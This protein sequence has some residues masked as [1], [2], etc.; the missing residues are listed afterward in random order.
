MKKYLTAVL[1]V[2]L[3]IG[4]A[5]MGNFVKAGTREIK[6]TDV[7]W[8]MAEGILKEKTFSGIDKIQKAPDRK[9]TREEYLTLLIRAA[10][11]SQNQKAY[12]KMDDRDKRNISPKYRGYIGKAEQLGILA[13]DGKPLSP[14]KVLTKADAAYYLGKLTGAAYYTPLAYK[15]CQKVSDAGIYIRGLLAANV[16][17]AQNGIRYQ[18]G[19][20]LSWKEAAGYIRKAERQGLFSAK[21]ISIYGGTFLEEKEENRLLCPYGIAAASDGSIYVADKGSN[22]IKRYENGTMRIIAGKYTGKDAYGGETGGYRDDLAAAAIFNHPEDLCIT[23]DGTIFV[24]DT[25]NHVIRRIKDGKVTTFAGSGKLGYADGNGGQASFSEPRGIACDEEG[26][27]YVAD[28]GNNCI[29]KI[30][31]EKEVTTFVGS[32]KEGCKE[33]RGKEAAFSYPTDVICEGKTWYVV[34]SGNQRI[35]RIKGEEQ[36]EVTTVAG[37]GHGIYD[38]HSRVMSEF[39][40]GRGKAAGFFSP[41]AV[42]ADGKGHLYV[43][44]AA[45]GRIRKISEKGNV[46]TIA[47]FSKP[48]WEKVSNAIVKPCGILCIDGKVLVTDMFQNVIFLM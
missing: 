26:N 30:S 8:L 34:D 7:D 28:S 11:L 39:Q 14:K 24:S 29:R 20:K 41:Y 22:T 37:G 48:A 9:I 18:P 38:K 17:P 16:I 31:K 33:G 6:K 27:L 15:D 21:T 25:D 43:T 44:E 23:E 36:P 32:D 46:T 3:C 5:F 40:D 42:A 4:M 47:G 45:S 10:G 1:A 12:Q 2:S 13:Y 19:K 35:C